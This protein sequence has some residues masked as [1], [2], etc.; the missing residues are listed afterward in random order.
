MLNVEILEQRVAELMQTAIVPGMALAITGR[1]ELIY[2]R[3]FGV[4]STE[5]GAASVTPETIFRIGS[6]TKTLTATM[7]MRL[8]D[9]GQLDLDRPVHDYVPWLRLADEAAAQAVTLRMLLSH[10]SGLPTALDYHG[11]RDASGLEAYVREVLP[12]LPPVAP[13][14][15]VY[16]YS[17]PGFNLAGYVAEAATGVP[18]AELMRRELFGP[19]GMTRTT[20]DP[21][22]AMTYRF[23]QSFILDEAGR[24]QVR[25]PFVD[26]TGEYP[27]GFA[28]SNV[29]DLARLARL[30][31]N[32]GCLDGGQVM[33]ASVLAGMHTLQ[34]DQMTLDGRGYGL[35]VRIRR[36]KGLR[37]VGHNGAIAKYAALWWLVPEAGIGV[38]M[39]IN[40]GPGVWGGADRLLTAILDDLL[41]LPDA[42]PLTVP[43]AEHEAFEDYAG[44]YLGPSVGLAQVDVD[45]EQLRLRWNGRPYLLELYGCG[46][47]RATTT[48]GDSLSVGFRRAP[49]TTVRYL[50]LNGSPCMRADMTLAAV[51]V[52]GW[53]PALGVYS[54]EL[55]S[56]RLRREGDQLW[57]YS[58][59]ER[60]EVPCVLLDERRFA[61]DF[62]LFELA[63]DAEGRLALL[64]G[65][66][67]WRFPKVVTP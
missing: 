34:T 43:T 54:D 10:T 23:S 7:L 19:L 41:A 65:G 9:H 56:F 61:C 39:L 46:Q 26:N 35:G 27:C 6:V 17:N 16:S 25:R 51:A 3:G 64:G 42:T 11:R 29:L 20:F 58:D 62:G 50:Y 8:V 12:T 5:P 44:A 47:F 53:E 32:G 30:H 14:G 59:D 37:L 36:Y 31:L 24:P 15:E 33:S 57:L 55:D 40:R 63:E 21:L 1:D 28:M 67:H 45:G 60:A 4:T 13:P 49:D 52:D 66:G 38:A 2:A 22:V 48:D 18:Y